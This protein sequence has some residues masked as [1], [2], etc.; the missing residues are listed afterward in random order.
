[1]R[2][3]FFVILIPAML[4]LSGLFILSLVRAWQIG[5]W[6][7]AIIA[8]AAFTGAIFV[9]MSVVRRLMYPRLAELED[10]RIVRQA[11]DSNSASIRTAAL[12][13]KVNKR[14]AITED[15]ASHVRLHS[16]G[17]SSDH[18]FAL[19]LFGRGV[20]IIFLSIVVASGFLFLLIVELTSEFWQAAWRTGVG[21]MFLS[22]FLVTLLFLLDS[23]IDLRACRAQSAR[24]TTC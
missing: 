21:P 9:F 4:L 18:A 6:E 14:A 20:S 15:D 13:E 7:P 22:L 2:V 16:L 11:I 23:R 17:V 19:R 24:R 5:I 8:G 3:Y 12:E 10:M 1:M